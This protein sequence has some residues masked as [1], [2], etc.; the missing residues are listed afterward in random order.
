[1]PK[2]GDEGTRTFRVYWFGDHIATL[3]YDNGLWMHSQHIGMK[4]SLSEKHGIQGTQVP[5]YLEALLPE[6]KDYFDPS[7]ERRASLDRPLSSFK[8]K[9]RTSIIDRL[10]MSDRFASN[11]T[12]TERG[13]PSEIIFDQLQGRLADHVNEKGEFCGRNK[14]FTE[15]EAA[16]VREEIA[17]ALRRHNAPKIS[18]VQTKA[19]VNLSEKGLLSPAI[20]KPFTHIMKL[21]GHRHEA[22]FDTMGANEFYTMSLVREAGVIT[23]DF[24]VLDV[25]GVGCCFLTER[26][27]IPV[28][29]K[30]RR[31][32]LEDFCS[33]SSRISN[34]KYEAG[35][36]EVGDLIHRYSSSPD[37]DCR[38]L[39]RQA[40]ASWCVGNS[41]M[42]LKN[43]SFI[44]TAETLDGF[45]SIRLSPAYD[46][47]CT[48]IYANVSTPH[49]A[50]D[51]NSER[52]LSVKDFLLLG[53]SM[54]IK[55]DEAIGVIADVSARISTAATDLIAAMPQFILDDKLSSLHLRKIA[56]LSTQRSI[57]MLNGCEAYLSGRKE[58]RRQFSATPG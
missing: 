37:E 28:G 47:M 48:M 57:D 18:G 16:M 30:F 4:M 45:T 20:N 6:V 43:L 42:H 50:L 51:I 46:I 49:S 54:G 53:R 29:G 23:E 39:L 40:A 32:L 8:T 52:D 13:D 33:A 12:V 24:A 17:K 14:V 56:L 2:R 38:M 22:E 34:E 3:E 26:F 55:E 9:E 10:S 19:P 35:M 1:M 36:L 41:D 25:P 27:D 7:S 15:L 21:P 44:K 58:K 31:M 11:V 5:Y